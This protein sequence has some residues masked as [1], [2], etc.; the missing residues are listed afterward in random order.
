MLRET[1]GMISSVKL[2]NS[3]FFIVSNKYIGK[4]AKEM[5]EDNYEKG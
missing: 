3:E 2:K 4:L 1:G 5:I